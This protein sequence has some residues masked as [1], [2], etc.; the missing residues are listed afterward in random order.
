MPREYVRV[1]G[2]LHGFRPMYEQRSNIYVDFAVL[3]LIR[4]V[5]DMHFAVFGFRWGASAE[6]NSPVRTLNAPSIYLP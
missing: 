6:R 2:G 1:S 3:F 5:A 4:R